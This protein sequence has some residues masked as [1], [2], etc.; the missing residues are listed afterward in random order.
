MEP[1]NVEEQDDE[2]DITMTV[3]IVSE[4]IGRRD[5]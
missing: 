5:Q 2:E 3:D 4:G 1:C